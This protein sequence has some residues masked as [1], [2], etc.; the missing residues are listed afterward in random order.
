MTL[1]YR[2]GVCPAVHLSPGH[3]LWRP[4]RDLVRACVC[5]P[6]AFKQQALKR[7]VAHS[8]VFIERVTGQGVKTALFVLHACLVINW[9]NLSVINIKS[10]NLCCN[11][12]MWSLSLFTYE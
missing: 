1:S 9:T 8:P 5:T 10:D 12:F 3:G 4:A 7:P 6:R 2:G 11:K